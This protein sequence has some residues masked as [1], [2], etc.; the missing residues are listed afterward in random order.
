MTTNRTLRHHYLFRTAGAVLLL[1]LTPYLA[2]TQNLK[3]SAK[4]ATKKSPLVKGSASMLSQSLPGAT[5]GSGLILASIAGVPSNDNFH[6][7]ARISTTA[8]GN[9][10]NATSEDG[11]LMN[12]DS[13]GGMTVWWTWTARA[14]GATTITTAG[15][16]FDTLLGVFTGTTV[17]DLTW[18]VA[19]DDDPTVDELRTS[20]VTFDATAGTVYQIAVDGYE[21]AN[22][23]VKIAVVP[24]GYFSLSVSA[25]PVEG[26]SVSGGGAFPANSTR[27]VTA[28]AGTG[29]LFRNWTEAGN[30]VSTEAG[31]SFHLVGDRM[32]VANFASRQVAPNDNFFDSI[33]ITDTAS[34]GNANATL[35]P[36]EPNT[37]GNGGKSV[38]WNWTAT[39]SGD[40]TI[41]TA[42][43]DFDTVMGVFT[44]ASVDALSLVAYDDDSGPNSTSSVHF[45]ATAG[46]TYQIAVDGF[47]AATGLIQLT[48]TPPP[49]PVPL[50]TAPFNDFFADRASFTTTASGNNLNAT[51]EANEPYVPAGGGRSAWWSWTATASGSVSIS[52]AGSNFDTVL[53]VFTGDSVDALNLIASNDDSDG[54]QSRVTFNAIAGTTYQV[55]VEGFSSNTGAIQLT[56]TPPE[57]SIARELRLPSLVAD[58]DSPIDVPVQLVAGGDEHS[59]GFT[60]NF[61][62]EALISGSV[63]LGA[64]AGGALLEVD[65]S[66]EADGHLGIR[67][68]QPVGEAFAAGT[69]E[70][71]RLQFTTGGTSVPT[72]SLSLRDVPVG[73]TVVD[74]SD[75]PLVASYTDGAVLF[76]RTAGLYVLANP[77]IGGTVTGAGSFAIDSLHQI[78]AAANPGWIFTGWNDNESA[79][80]RL[81]TIPVGGVAYIAHFSRQT[82]RSQWRGSYYGILDS[83]VAG[84]VR[85]TINPQGGFSASVQIDGHPYSFHGRLNSS[86]AYVGPVSKSGWNITLQLNP[87][88]GEITGQ[89]SKADILVDL[90]ISRSLWNAHG[91]TVALEGK[92]TFL[93]QPNGDDSSTPRGQ[94][95]GT[96]TIT[97]TGAIHLAGKLS[98]GT[99]FTQGAKVTQNLSWPL[100]ATLYWNKGYVSGMVSFQDQD[101]SD[102]S[103]V[104][105]WY[106]PARLKELYSHG[107]NTQVSLIGSG[108][109]PGIPFSVNFSSA[110]LLFQD[111]DQNSVFEGGFSLSKGANQLGTEPD[112]DNQS[113]WI[114]LDNR[115][116]SLSG[117]LSGFFIDRFGRPAGTPV[118]GVI[119]QKTMSAGGYFFDGVTN[120]AFQIQTQ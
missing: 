69:Q 91:D 113:V 33:T 34:G 120:G 57:G 53:G 3:G 55:A 1:L 7:R 85:V 107:I 36:G 10:V 41:T 70:V 9:N 23:S 101:Q 82:P 24:P 51:Q 4:A 92:Y 83:G 21:G 60:V 103:G 86:A 115:D 13:P 111:G 58:A 40:A 116:G 11:E 26:G 106:K 38:W 27:K 65:R 76:N 100:C 5:S 62:P 29:Y 50:S 30:I 102:L 20:R 56:V 15:S 94:G 43:S 109:T 78:E 77:V 48:V 74:T 81:V 17:D 37:D 90:H 117:N 66:E 49:L 12:G 44:G 16:S 6:N 18:V 32:L 8:T 42:G 112:S 97:R 96:I 105:L 72:A 84:L 14:S 19:N 104:L 67:L 61:D 119:L 71:V 68:T 98:D 46:A 31:Y 118:H 45:A 73:R 93:L 64:G 39:L 87:S 54:L 35:E 63:Q 59:V 95:Y 99:A 22:G 25:S 52:T 110:S 79:T 80:P 114:R 2:F 108:Y 89:L 47:G 88:T 75:N 28:K